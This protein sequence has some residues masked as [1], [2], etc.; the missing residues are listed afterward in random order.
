MAP[1]DTN[2]DVNQRPAV[3]PI[4]VIAQDPS[5]HQ[6]GAHGKILTTKVRIFAEW[7]GKGPRSHRF[8]VVDYDETTREYIEPRDPLASFSGPGWSPYR[9][10]FEKASDET[11]VNDPHFRAQNVFV[12]ASRTLDAFESA[13]GRRVPW[14]FG[15]QQLT[16]VPHAL[17]MEN[18]YYEAGD[19]SIYFGYFKRA[20]GTLVQTSLSHDIIAHETTHAILDGLR[21]RLLHPGLPDEAAFHEGLAD[22]VA[23]LSVFSMT[24]VVEEAI[25]LAG[26]KDKLHSKTEVLSAEAFKESLFFTLAEQWPGDDIYGHE[27]IGLRSSIFLKPNDDWITNPDYEEC[28]LRGEVLVAA[29][30]QTLLDIWF[31][32]IKLLVEGGQ[33]SN[34]LIAEE[35]AKSADHLLKMI[36]SGIDYM[37]P[38]ELEYADVLEAVLDSD[39]AIVPND[40][41]SYRARL[42]NAFAS[43]GI[44]LPAAS[45]L[46]VDP[47]P[48]YDNLNYTLLR[49]SPEEAFQFIWNNA[50][51]LGIEREL[52][53]VVDRV[54]PCVRVGPDGIIVEETSV[55]YV[56]SAEGTL[57]ELKELLGESFALDQ[58]V[59]RRKFQIWGGGTIIFDQFGRVR[60]H[61]AK[62]LRCGERQARRIDYLLRSEAEDTEARYGYASPGPPPSLHGPHGR[63]RPP[64]W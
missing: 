63:V 42:E 29:V 6:H 39:A 50:P 59:P 62:P 51:L 37:P 13:L 48:V 33:P 7:L 20:D 15:G 1:T 23:L 18:A 55:T 31:F 5:I 28:H 64:E 60:R 46:L 27:V 4:T 16:L 58:K 43:W 35:G 57:N 9:D 25:A 14:S 40:D 41:Y 56:Q 26:G 53:T 36:L 24:D 52:D 17:V 32:R 34:K 30:M 2:K 47:S 8:H 54:V 45:A 22:I 3:F 21:P 44:D 11:L 38:T 10:D 12:I 61:H 19:Q 49:T